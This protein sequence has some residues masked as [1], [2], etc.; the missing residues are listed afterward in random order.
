MRGKP[1]VSLAAVPG[2]RRATI[3][4]SQRLEREGF[5]GLYCPSLGDGLGLCEAL[6]FTTREIPFGT[7][8]ANI[9]ARHP[10]DY[11]QSA[12]FIHEVS[13]GRFRF[14]VGVSHGPA[15]DRL[16][17]NPGKPLADVRRFVKQIETWSKQAGELPPIVL[18]T[19]RKGMVAL[20]GEIA[21]G[22]VWANAARAHMS[23]SLGHLPPAARQDPTFFI[24]NM[25]P[26]CIDDDRA[27]AAAVSRRALT[28]Y[29]KLP[30][31][32]N[33]WIEAGFEDEMQAIRRAIAA[34]EEERIPGLMSD[35]W[36]SEVTL[37]GS[38]AEVRDGVEA[39]Y[40][41][42]ITTLIVVPSSARGNQ[43]AALQQLIDLYR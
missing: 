2:R 19:L 32:Q 41:T 25:V 21:Q 38:P 36:L 9:Y 18:A 42:G 43:M 39:W 15:H 26:T 23:T 10:S 17:V 14:G 4:V 13:G 8:I 24:A 12:A 5:S 37:Y 31:Y 11:A 29:V 3:E 27:A 35:R 16:G 28:G 30:N 7:S 22:A 20:A 33:Y 34:G 6:A 40:E 1:A